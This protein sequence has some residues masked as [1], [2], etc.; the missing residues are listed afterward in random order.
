M[1]TVIPRPGLRS[2]PVPSPARAK[3][4]G[5]PQPRP[6]AVVVRAAGPADVAALYGL[7]RAFART[8]EL[9]ERPYG[10]YVRDVRDFLVAE[11]T[12]GGVAGC[13]GLRRLPGP[14]G[15]EGPDVPAVPGTPDGPR[16]PDGPVPARFAVVYNFC[17]AAA[18]Q[19]RGVG[20][21]LLGALLAEAADRAVGTL[22]TAT[23][24]DAT[25]F[26]RHGF[27]EVPDPAAW[28][29]ALNPRTGSLVL[30]RTL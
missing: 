6:H 30:R 24:G 29:A 5:T 28:P 25:L 8:G 3:S 17:V 23:S 4:A 2:A 12:G 27:T 10:Q 14:D 21:A 18:S 1:T 16:A 7:S 20:S 9:R 26:L 19:G 13:V 22:Y 15:R 11:S